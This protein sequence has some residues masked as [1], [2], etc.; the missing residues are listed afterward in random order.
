MIYIEKAGCKIFFKNKLMETIK[1]E[2]VLEPIYWDKPPHAKIKLNGKEYYSNTVT[3]K[4]R[5]VFTEN[6]VFGTHLLEIV[7]T[8]KTDD[9]C[10]NEE[11]DQ[12]LLLNQIKIDGINIRNIIWH[13]GYYVPNYPKLWSLYQK[14]QGIELEEKV[15]GETIFAHNGT[16]QLKFTSPFYR[17]IFDW[18]EDKIKL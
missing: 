8:N 18:M 12:K 3:E 15:K 16:W 2:I 7:R 4:T 9:Q 1:F 6:I 11:K 13:Y 14:K 5:V 17:F 10:I